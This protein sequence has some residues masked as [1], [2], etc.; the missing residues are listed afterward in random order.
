M[1]RAQESSRG[2]VESARLASVG[3]EGRKRK[4]KVKKKSKN[5]L[6][7]RAEVGAALG[8]GASGACCSGSQNVCDRGHGLAGGINT[9]VQKNR[10][11]GFGRCSVKQCIRSTQP[12]RDGAMGIRDNK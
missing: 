2:E 10:G 8:D 7:Y 12:P 5:K 9:R 3:L 11:P 6:V 4:K 1:L